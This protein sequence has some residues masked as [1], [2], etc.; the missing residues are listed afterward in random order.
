MVMVI[1]MMMIIIIVVILITNNNICRAVDLC[2]KKIG[3]MEF[4]R[5]SFLLHIVTGQL[6]C[7]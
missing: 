2:N 6:V 1:M 4:G 5:I 7:Y 3:F